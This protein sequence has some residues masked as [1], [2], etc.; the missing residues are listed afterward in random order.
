MVYGHEVRWIIIII[1]NTIEHVSLLIY[2]NTVCTG[3]RWRELL[4]ITQNRKTLLSG[5]AEVHLFVRE[6]DDTKDRMS[7]KVWFTY[8]VW[9]A[10]TVVWYAGTIVWYAGTVVWYAGIVVW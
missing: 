2:T 9:Y 7:D 6:A 5:A 1:I 8:V 4:G 3:C 10:G